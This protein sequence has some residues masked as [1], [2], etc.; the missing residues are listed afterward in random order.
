MTSPTPT[1]DEPRSY[2]QTFFQP[3]DGACQILLVRHGQSAPFVEGRPFPLVEGQGNPP[4]SP[5]GEWQADRVGHRLKKEPIDALY[6]S[7]L[8][9]TTQT[10]LPLARH[11]GHELS[12]EPDLREIHLGEGEGG[13]FRQM[14]AEEHPAALAMRANRQW[15]EIPGA[16]NNEEFTNRTVDAVRRIAAA[17]TDQL[18]AA[19][20]HGGTIGAILGYAAGVNPFTFNGTRNGA[21]AHLVVA[22]EGWV[23]RSFNDGAHV[24]P[25]TAD[26]EPPT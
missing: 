23:I 11:L 12:I 13:K 7:T 6:V 18:V 15:G 10:A 22:E 20:C 19:F 26:A 4:L 9:R 14:L 25:L 8:Q 16:E 21:I 1:G 5:L 17:H 24:G 3:P 2:P